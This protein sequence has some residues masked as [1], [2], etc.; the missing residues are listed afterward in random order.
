MHL[1]DALGVQRG[2]VVAF[3]GAGGKTSALLRLGFE[4]HAQG[5]RVL[6]TT[7][8]RIAQAEIPTFPQAIRLEQVENLPQALNQHG[9]LFLYDRLEDDKALGVSP[10]SIYQI[11][12][13]VNSDV[14]LIEADGSRRKPLKAPYPHEPVIPP[15][16]TLVVVVA[17]MDA[18]GQ[19]FNADAVYNPESVVEHYGF[20]LEMPIQPAW[21]AQVVRH[22]E[23]GLQGVPEGARVVAL[24][25]K[26]ST[27]MVDRLRTR[28]TAQLI[29][30]QPRIN[31]VAI[32][33]VQMPDNPIF[34]VQ[35]QVA[36][37]VLA[38]GLSS[39][40]GRSKPLLPWGDNT[41]IDTIVHH[42]QL[43]RL[44]DI[45]VVTGYRNKE[46]ER[47]IKYR[48][49][50]TVYNRNYATGEMLSSFKTGLAALA[51]NISACL[52]FLGDQPQIN[53]RLVNEILVAYAEGKGKIVAPSYQNRR[54]HP[55]LIDR[56][57]W[58][59]LLDLPS[60][61]APRNVINAYQAETAYVL[62]DDE[63]VLR[64]MDTPEE[65]QEALRR[66]GLK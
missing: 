63:N 47:A 6:A 60:D 9:F 59:E 13:Q 48:R 10:E 58:R 1:Y 8:T 12:D 66:A 19:P 11:S 36:A 16:T 54:G 51:P 32:G 57:Y 46:V 40:M 23:I 50:R 25:N 65:Y 38:G 3:V 33:Q 27:H 30:Q 15:E 37:L 4:L 62:T 17:G 22:E 55:I 29:L 20:P 28:R 2:D 18:V 26:T 31:A 52:I 34:E 41:V 21:V 61:G 35:R 7:T 49:V 44:S 42:L 39:R 5:W 53:T 56:R 45:V 24:L 64:D 43:M 14:I